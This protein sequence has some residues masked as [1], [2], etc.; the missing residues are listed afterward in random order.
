MGIQ[1]G[2]AAGQKKKRERNNRIQHQIV[3]F[4]YF[5]CVFLSVSKYQVDTIN[6]AQKI[7]EN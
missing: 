5:A 4:F 6:A 7:T 2:L 3:F 1:L